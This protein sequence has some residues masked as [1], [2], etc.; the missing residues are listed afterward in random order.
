[1][2]C[3]VFIL[4][5]GLGTRLRPLT[6][7]V[8]KPLIEI[9]GKSLLEW[10]LERLQRLGFSRVMI[11]LHYLPEQIK[12]FVGDGSRWG[13]AVAYSFEPTLLDTGG[14][15]KN[16]ESWIKSEKLLVINSDSFF[17]EDPP[18]RELIATSSDMA[19]LV[20]PDRGFTK[21]SVNSTG[22]LTGFDTKSNNG[23]DAVNYL[24]VMKLNRS[25]VAELSCGVSS[26]TKDYIPDLLKNGQLI[27]SVFYGGFWSD[28]GTP[29]RLAE[30]ELSP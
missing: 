14:G 16:I 30:I 9:K 29:E 27:E 11:N 17:G 13:L 8:P 28:I 6:E 15:I 26:I 10:H 23:G 18:L 5:A 2:S 3:D 21:L 12:E 7:S 25:F 1:M 4:A 22:R 20:G 19:L 24:G